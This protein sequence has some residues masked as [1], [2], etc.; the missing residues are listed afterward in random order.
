MA[1]LGTKSLLVVAWMASTTPITSRFAGFSNGSSSSL[2]SSFFFAFSATLTYSARRLLLTNPYKNCLKVLQFLVLCPWS[3]WYEH[4]NFVVLATRFPPIGLSHLKYG[5][6]WISNI[7]LCIGFVNTID[8]LYPSS[9]TLLRSSF[10]FLFVFSIFS[11][12]LPPFSY[13]FSSAAP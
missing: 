10:L 3:L 6:L 12:T 4:L 9:L 8:F 5:W 11:L 7:N 2:F 1:I 13:F